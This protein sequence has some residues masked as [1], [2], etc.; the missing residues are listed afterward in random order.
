MTIDT[1]RLADVI[2]QLGR[3]EEGRDT[4]GAINYLWEE[5]IAISSGPDEARQVLLGTAAVCEVSLRKQFPIG[6]NF[7][8]LALQT[9]SQPMMCTFQI[10]TALLN[11]DHQTAYALATSAVNQGPEWADDVLLAMMIAVRNIQRGGVGEIGK[12]PVEEDHAETD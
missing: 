12:S 9:D 1:K 5:V 11:Q 3:L 6:N 8:S 7:V 4:F 2:L 10:I